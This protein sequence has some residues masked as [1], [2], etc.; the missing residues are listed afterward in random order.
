MELMSVNKVE[1]TPATS[2]AEFITSIPNQTLR[3]RRRWAR[4]KKT[5]VFLPVYSEKRNVLLRG[6]ISGKKLGRKS[7]ERNS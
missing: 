6:R 2:I 3:K 1:L 4:G 7:T 5:L